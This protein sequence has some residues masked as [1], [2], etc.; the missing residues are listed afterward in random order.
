[1]VN[2]MG[3]EIV[4]VAAASATVG[5]DLLRVGDADFASQGYDR[6]LN[7]VGL[8]GSAAAGDT[9]VDIYIDDVKVFPNLT[10]TV[11]SI[12]APNDHI[13][14]IEARY[15]PANSK[16]KAKVTDAPATNPIYLLLD[17]ERLE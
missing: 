2:G 12:A 7:G 8:T 1:M 17:V 3:V 14:P 5:V 15:I 9:F 11:T 16:L 10:N 13:I 4:V 6:S